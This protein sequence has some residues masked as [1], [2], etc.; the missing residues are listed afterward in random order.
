MFGSAMSCAVTPVPSWPTIAKP[1]A[2]VKLTAGIVTNSP[3]IPSSA[4]PGGAPA[5]FAALL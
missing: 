5:A 2:R 3:L 4:I 1:S